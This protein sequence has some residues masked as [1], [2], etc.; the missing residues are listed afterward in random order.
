[1]LLN[2]T[3]ADAARTLGGAEETIDGLLDRWIERTVDG[4]P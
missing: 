1:M 2:A 4:A 3:G